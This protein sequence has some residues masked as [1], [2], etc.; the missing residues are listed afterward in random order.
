MGWSDSPTSIDG[1]GDQIW[2][3]GGSSGGEV[4]TLK[5]VF[6]ENAALGNLLIHDKLL[7]V[8]SH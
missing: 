4:L 6:D 2:D 5:H 3:N 7:V 1:K 8:R